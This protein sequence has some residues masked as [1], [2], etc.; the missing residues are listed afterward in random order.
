[1]IY[2]GVDPGKKGALGLIERLRR[3]VTGRCG[4]C[5]RGDSIAACW[6]QYC[7]LRSPEKEG[8]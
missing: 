5:R 4:E 2:L 6:N 3:W 8:E 7:P 1:M